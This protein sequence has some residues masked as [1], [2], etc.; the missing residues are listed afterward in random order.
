MQSSILIIDHIPTHR[1]QLKVMFARMQYDIHCVAS[2]A[3]AREYLRDTRPV[4]IVVTNSLADQKP[5]PFV[6]ELKARED[7]ASVPVLMLSRSADITTL[8]A[9]RAGAADLFNAPFVK[10]LILTRVRS[11]LRNSDT[12][13]D[14]WVREA[15]DCMTGLS[16]VQRPFEAVRRVALLTHGAGPQTL[17]LQQLQSSK[18]Y[19]FSQLD[20]SQ[21]PLAFADL[22]RED[23]VMIV[24]HQ[25]QREQIAQTLVE[26]RAHPMLR[27]IG[28]LVLGE[29][30]T[31]TAKHLYDIGANEVQAQEVSGEEVLLR[32]GV[33]I[34]KKKLS[35][36]HKQ[37]LMLSMQAAI[38]D[39]LTG[40][41]NRRFALPRL[42]K[43]LK[44][45]YLRNRPCSVAMLDIDHFRDVNT[46]HGHVVGDRVLRKVADILRKNTGSDDM[47]ARMGGEEFLIVMPNATS[48][49]AYAKVE[50][51]RQAVRLTPMAGRADRGAFFV[52]VSLGLVSVPSP[53]FPTMP[54]TID[55]L[56]ASAD[57][58]LYR[59][60]EAGRNQVS[61]A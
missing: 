8:D 4:L 21:G 31:Q 13:Q 20:A 48:Q 38:V 54:E 7:L 56:I 23:A 18:S 39:P 24:G 11:L 32:L 2:A 17:L 12:A 9:L 5:L 61:L 15:A 19:R 42:H 16:E 30:D 37:S 52:S 33:L 35:E 57:A 6:C 34:E 44:D 46:Q 50:E 36:R 45:A 27:D 1:V 49:E 43:T 51:L 14:H 10:E 47:I 22:L 26:L 41:F 40:V 58:A 28:V 59:S 3:Q 60:K 25:C 53:E 55:E 29:F